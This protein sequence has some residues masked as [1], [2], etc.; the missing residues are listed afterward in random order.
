MKII[1]RTVFGSALQTALYQGINH[2]VLPYTTLNQAV[3]LP[4][5][6]PFQP[7]VL[8]A[9]MEVV[10]DYDMEDDTQ[11]M[12]SRYFCIGN[13]GHRSIEGPGGIWYTAP[14]P[15]KSSDSGLYGLIPFAVREIHPTNNDFLP[16]SVERERYRLRKVVEKG[17]KLYAAY[18]L[19]V[20]DVSNVTPEMVLTVIDGAT[21][22]NSIFSPSINNLKP[23]VPEVGVIT[24]GSYLSTTSNVTVTLTN[25]EITMIRDACALLFDNENLAIISE[26]GIVQAVDKLV[27]HYYPTTGTQTQTPVVTTIHE[28]VAAQVGCHVTTHYPLVYLNDGFEF[29][30]DSGITEPLFG[31]NIA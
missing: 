20:M 19:R 30:I 6:V 31:Q 25:D 1:T 13:G 22:T 28:V 10:P 14:I 16:G 17:G 2:E 29:T 15:H 7:A 21:E 12:R 23:P 4:L 27:T 24:D 26:I 18:Y 5:I 9:G 8:T 11:S 3:S